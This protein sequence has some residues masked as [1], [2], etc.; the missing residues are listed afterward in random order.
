MDYPVPNF[1]VDEDIKTSLSNLNNSEKKFGTW[2]LPK[3][4]I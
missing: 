3:E 2:D 1:G 4:D